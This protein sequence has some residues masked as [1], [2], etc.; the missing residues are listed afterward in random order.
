MSRKRLCVFYN[1]AAQYLFPRDIEWIL[2]KECRKAIERG[3]LGS[4]LED[5]HRNYTKE[6][7]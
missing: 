6:E 3:E 1:R 2:C 4:I 5:A 7:K